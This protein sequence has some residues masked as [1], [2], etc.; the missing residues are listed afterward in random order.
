MY[1]TGHY[2]AALLVYAPVGFALLSV[3]PALAVLGSVGSVALSRVP[4]YDLRVPFLEHRGV[5]H[6]LPFLAA[7][8]ALL[9]AVGYRAAGAVGTDPARTGTPAS[10]TERLCGSRDLRR[11]VI[12]S[13]P[14]RH[15]EGD[16]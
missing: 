5:T 2:G 10:P 7:V 16:A 1:K 15:V 9:G 8:A 4:D 6:T 14:T 13:R 3:D 11:P 12:R